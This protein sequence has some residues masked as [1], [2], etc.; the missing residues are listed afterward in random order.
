MRVTFYVMRYGNLFVRFARFAV[1]YRT[2]KAQNSQKKIRAIRAIRG[3]LSVLRV[4]FYVLYYA[5]EPFFSLDCVFCN[6]LMFM[7]ET[8]II[9]KLTVN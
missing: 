4:A 5:L 7:N 2:Q 3:S 9:H 8:R 6:T 1:L